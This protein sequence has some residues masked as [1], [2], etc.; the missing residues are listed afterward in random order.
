MAGLKA[1]RGLLFEDDIHADYR[2]IIRIFYGFGDPKRLESNI[3]QN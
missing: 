1:R 3:S 2:Y